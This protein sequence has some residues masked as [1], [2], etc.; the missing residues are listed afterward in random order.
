MKTAFRLVACITGLV[1][2]GAAAAQMNKPFA[3]VGDIDIL[4]PFGARGL[5]PLSA[6]NDKLVAAGFTPKSAPGQP[7]CRF[8]YIR[9]DEV[10]A[11]ISV[12]PLTGRRCRPDA[13]LGW[14]QLIMSDRRPSS[15]AEP[16]QP[17]LVAAAWKQL[18]GEPHNC[19]AAINCLWTETAQPDVRRARIRQ[20][21]S[22]GRNGA[23]DSSTLHLVLFYVDP[24]EKAAKAKAR[25]ED[26]E[27]MRLCLASGEHRW[28][29]QLE[30][31]ERQRP[32]SV[33]R[34]NRAPK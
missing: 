3:A 10:T 28:E 31:T 12:K 7:A 15:H 14:L 13:R 17:K 6:L 32:G 26:A 11:R 22:T 8:E 33:I 2:V 9:K 25:E 30:L 4:T 1:L 27:F 24:A 19:S 34:V 23:A 21:V 16:F 29:C 5:M 20:A 18:L